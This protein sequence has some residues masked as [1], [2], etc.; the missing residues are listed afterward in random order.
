[1]LKKNE[2]MRGEMNRRVIY[3]GGDFTQRV[4]KR[5][6]VDAVI[7]KRGRPKKES[8]DKPIK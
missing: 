8:A 5:Y 3:G 2:S 7:K 4:N 1:M 6:K